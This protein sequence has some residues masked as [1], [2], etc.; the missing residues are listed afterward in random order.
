MIRERVDTRQ[1]SVTQHTTNYILHRYYILL[2]SL[3]IQTDEHMSVIRRHTHT[4]TR[5]RPCKTIIGY[6]NDYAR[7]GRSMKS[8]S[9]DDLDVWRE[10]QLIKCTKQ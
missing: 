5:E 2:K 4:H 9:S 7:H 6:P 8:I 10:C 1:P 3:P